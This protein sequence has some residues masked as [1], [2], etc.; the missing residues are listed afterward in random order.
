MMPRLHKGALIFYIGRTRWR[1]HP[2]CF[3]MGWEKKDGQGL[4]S[5]PVIIITWITR[6]RR[7]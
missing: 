1:F 6:F 4:L 5:L 7:E 3:R 2:G